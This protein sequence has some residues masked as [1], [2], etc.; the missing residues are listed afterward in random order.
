M[1][2]IR[3]FFSRHRA[4]LLAVPVDAGSGPAIVLVHGIASSSK[5]FAALLPYISA[6]HRVIAIDLLGFGTS[7]APLDSQ[8]TL[9]DHVD[10][11]ARTIDS[12]RID[13]PFVL[14]GHSLGCLISSRYTATH[15]KRVAR[16]VL[17]SPPVYLAPHEIADARDRNEVTGYLA[18]Y[19]YLR[20]NKRF[21]LANAAFVSHALRLKDVMDITEK[22]WI[23]FE[24]SMEHCIEQQ[25][26]ITDLARID[27]PIE[28]AYGRLDEFV[29]TSSM[30]LIERIKG[31][32]V[33]PVNVSD[34]MI[35]KPLARVAATAI[36]GAW[37]R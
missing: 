20:A 1:L 32:T 22:N 17:I 2:G 31:V 19:Q 12:L 37:A 35:R 13:G 8:Y 4:P 3:E 6:G 33:H 25:T 34:H 29:T 27:V 21:T 23:P 18:A 30:R 26:I 11:V 36:L 9:E 10:A 15:K 7:P 16:L 5:A 28:I 14:V 24:R